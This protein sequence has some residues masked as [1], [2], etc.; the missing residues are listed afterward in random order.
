MK[1]QYNLVGI[2]NTLAILQDVDTHVK[3]ELPVYAMRQYSHLIVP[4]FNPPK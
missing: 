1:R 2:S 3:V 4:I